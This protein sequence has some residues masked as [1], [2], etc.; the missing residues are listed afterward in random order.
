MMKNLITIAFMLACSAISA[1]DTTCVM[2]TQNEII[3][4]DY[5]TSVVIDREPIGD[6]ILLRV[7]E[8]EVLCLHLHDLKR[9]FRDVTTAFD[10]GDYRYDTFKSKDNVYYTPF[11]FGGMVV[12]IG[13]PRKTRN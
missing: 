12:T 5:Q 1:Q 3:N 13:P 8:T 10:D 11:G 9:R 4:F 6:A 7:K 2:I